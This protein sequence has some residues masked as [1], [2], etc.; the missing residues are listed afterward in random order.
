MRAGLMASARLGCRIGNGGS[1][2]ADHLSIELAWTEHIEFG[3][4][5]A[6]HRAPAAANGSGL[7]NAARAVRAA[8]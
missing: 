6:H 4:H 5:S 3:M 8:R 7:F 2:A 1:A